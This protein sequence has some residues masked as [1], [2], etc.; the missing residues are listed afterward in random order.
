MKK[1]VRIL[2]VAVGAVVALGVLGIAGLIL[3]FPVD[4]LR[5]RIEKEAARA[6]G[7]AVGIP[8]LKLGWAAGGP[9]FTAR[10]VTALAP[11]G[12]QSIRI[13]ALDLGVAF[14]PL[15]RREVRVTRA[16]ARDVVL[17]MQPPARRSA[18]PAPSPGG[19]APGAAGALIVPRIEVIRGTVIQK[20]PAGVTTLHGVDL[21]GSFRSTATGGDLEGTVAADSITIVQAIAPGRP[22]PLPRLEL[23]FHSEI[24]TREMSASTEID[25][26]LGALPGRGSV[27]TVYDAAAGGW[28]NSGTIEMEPVDLEALKGFIAGPAAATLA[29]YALTGR[30]EGGKLRFEAGPSPDHLDYEFG[31]RWTGVTASLPGKGRVVDS[32]RGDLSVRPDDLRATG[33]LAL[34]QARLALDA[35]V[36]DFA[37][38]RWR[39]HLR[40]A[41]PASEA[42]RF[43]PPGT[44]LEATGG[45]LDLDVNASGLA[46]AKTPPEASGTLKVDGL[47]FRHPAL[48]VPVDRLDLQASF[49]GQAVRVEQGAIRAGRSDARFSGS[50]PDFRRPALD[51]TVAAGTVDLDQLFPAAPAASSPAAGAKPAG[52]VAGV[53]V[54]G[55]ITIDRLIR[56]K[57]ALE[58]VA[59]RF[60]VR[61]DGVTLEELKARAYGGTV[62]GRLTLTPAGPRALDYNGMFVVTDVR[63]ADLL[64][65]TTPIRGIEG[66]LRTRLNLSGRA[67]PGVDPR[68]ALSLLGGG[69]VLD[70]A[71]I[72]IPAVARVAKALNFQAG[73]GNRIPFKT[74]RHSVRV[75]NGFVVLDTL[76]LAEA[77]SDWEI[78]GRVGLDGRLD[79]PIR[80]RIAASALSSGS[81]L[82]K[83]ADV[84]AG[85][86]GRLAVELTLKGT[87]TSPDVS[88]N[89]DPLLEAARTKA[90]KSAGE[91]IKNRL[92]DLLRKRLA[93][94]APQG[95][96]AARPDS[97]AGEPRPG[98]AA[99]PADSLKR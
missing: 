86:D 38:P 70:G 93:G 80:V 40:L 59:A 17:E 21:D 57:L 35:T 56:Q 23:R 79:C 33:D 52:A 49:A 61:K 76:R 24:R 55:R 11:D 84:L 37:A 18:G 87:L 92:G 82:R 62:T 63:V 44:G 78:G 72:N 48:A 27:E 53:P 3:F 88:V 95:S 29:T 19:A 74:L 47:A 68:G 39:A 89:L 51:L 97:A 2:L 30:L 58:D 90:G 45:R 75:E 31:A 60:D 28:R 25:G 7:Y 36:A 85:P 64:A 26:R 14:W 98:G 99:A 41:G 77:S 69:L 91:E 73:A 54:T 96:G 5:A 94:G 71:L 12:S 43:L 50:V 9:V 15:L 67:E 42:L 22:L 10:D 81:D 83:L 13:P 8:S 34:G 66:T 1:G 4:A 32:G 6:T 65:A 20:G 16:E 46:A